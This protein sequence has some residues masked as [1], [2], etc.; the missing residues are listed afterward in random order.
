MATT[1]RVI[2]TGAGPVAGV[3]RRVRRPG[4]AV[5]GRVAT[6]SVPPP[7]PSV[8]RVGRALHP[9]AW[10]GWAIGVAVAASVSTQPL[11]LLALAGTVLA[12][13]LLRRDDSPWA[14][15]IWAYVALAVVVVLVRLTFVV[16]L[17]S[18]GG[19][20][21][22]F[23]LPR[24]P[25]PDWAAGVSLGGPVMA[26]RLLATGYDALR[27]GVMLVAL[28]AANALANP[29]RALR[30]VPSALHDVSVAVV[31]AITVV[32]QLIESTQ[33]VIRARRLRGGRV[34]GLR[35]VR[36]VAVPVL[37]DA[38]DRSLSLAAAME[39]RGYG[40][41]VVS[42]RGRPVLAGS[43]MLTGVVA[44][45][46]GIYLVL[47]GLDPAYAAVALFG[48][49]L[50]CLGG[51]ALSGRRVAATRYRPDPWRRAE[52]VVLG[53]GA[54]VAVAAAW[55]AD[56]A[57]EMLQP[58]VTLAWPQLP[59]GFVGLLLLVA[60]PLLAAPTPPRTGGRGSP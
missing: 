47:S 13:V 27:L 21:E 31:I 11:F 20:T 45:T 42:S 9:W 58:P 15:A 37:E 5:P 3:P 6:A 50:C 44:L 22:L 51:M 38:V 56:R 46:L 53:A 12:V 35:A 34:R 32:P 30:S 14:R 4:S 40:R 54:A 55:W 29:K 16:L 23:A 17:G 43:V 59:L 39:S 18:G 25:L 60:L 24:I 41:T 57:P 26:E 48:G 52:W 10:W 19:T 8:R 36:A 2:A 33:R 28:G 1:Q 7:D 49:A